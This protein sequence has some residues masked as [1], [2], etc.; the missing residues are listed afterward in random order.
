MTF[1]SLGHQKNNENSKY[2]QTLLNMIENSKFCSF[3]AIWA[4]YI[5]KE[6]IFHVEFVSRQKKYNLFFEELKKPNF[7]DSYVKINADQFSLTARS[8]NLCQE[9]SK[10]K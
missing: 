8:S 3:S 10:T 1:S 9:I 6:D 4:S 2:S 5:S 7:S